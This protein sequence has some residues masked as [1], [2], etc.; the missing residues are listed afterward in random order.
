M[1]QK[2][3]LSSYR[4]EVETLRWKLNELEVDS[5]EQRA[6]DKV[7]EWRE[8]FDTSSSSE[9]E[10]VI[11]KMEKR[12]QSEVIHLTSELR[13]SL[14]EFKEKNLNRLAQ[15]DAFILKTDINDGIQLDYIK[16]ELNIIMT[17]IDT[18]CID[19]R[20]EVVNNLHERRSS[21]LLA[22]NALKLT[23]VFE[24]KQPEETTNESPSF[25]EPVK[26]FLRRASSST[27]G[28]Y[29]VSLLDQPEH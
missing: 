1:D 20:V 18:L 13:T 12:K 19:I 25:F 16:Y 8:S 28:Y 11:D 4:S 3:I 24:C 27:A 9:M 10:R 2:H 29:D 7:R 23:K 22:R 26:N 21:T 15:L 6:A 14:E 5:V 17:E